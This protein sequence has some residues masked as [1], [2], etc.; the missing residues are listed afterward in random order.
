MHAR[1]MYNGELRQR[2]HQPARPIRRNHRRVHARADPR[3]RQKLGPDNK[4][5]DTNCVIPTINTPRL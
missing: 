4:E 1:P 5:H 2:D 3:R